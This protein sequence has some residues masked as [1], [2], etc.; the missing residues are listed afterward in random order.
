MIIGFII[1]SIVSI[2]FVG[3]GISCHKSKESVGFFTFM[4]APIVT[5][6]ERY[7]NAVAKLWIVVAC[8][9]E[10]I[11]IPLLFLEQNSPLFTPVIFAIVILVIV[12]IIVYIRIEVQYRK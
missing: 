7:N 8:A 9:F 6:I 4:K 2:V 3:I 5:D 1:W 11:G 12:M 10:I